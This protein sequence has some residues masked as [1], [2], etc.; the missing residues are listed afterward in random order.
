M[1]NDDG[2]ITLI[3]KRELDTGDADDDFVIPLD[4]EFDIGYAFNPESNQL[5]FLTKHQIA[6]SV[7]IML[8]SDGNP[9]WGD[10]IEAE[11]VNNVSEIDAVIST[12]TDLAS[13]LFDS[14]ANLAPA[15]AGAAISMAAI[16][17]L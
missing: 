12:I 6:G 4:Q 16:S 10:F 17:T 7:R 2:S 5:T 8:P 9:V 13:Q 11:P 15:I 1:Q 14:A 3:V